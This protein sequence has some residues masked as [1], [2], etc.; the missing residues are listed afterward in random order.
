M[1]AAALARRVFGFLA[2][3]RRD[4]W[5]YLIAPP[6]LTGIFV[7]FVEEIPLSMTLHVLRDISVFVVCLGVP[8]HLVYVNFGERLGLQ[9]RLR[10][11]ELPIHAAILGGAV[12]V[13]TEVAFAILDPLH[14]APLSSSERIPSRPAIWLIGLVGNALVSAVM[15][16]IGGYRERIE[17]MQLRELRARHEALSA[18][19]QA[20]QAR[21]QPHFLFNSLNTVASLI[22][23][24]P[25]RAEAVVEKLAD[26]FRYTLAA[27]QR[28]FVPL[29]DEIDAVASFLELEALRF[30]ERL[31]AALHADPQAAGVPV[32]PLLLQPLVENAVL[33]GIAPR[34]EGGRLEVS[35]ARRAGRL[36]LCVEDDGPGPGGSPRRGSG[37]ALADLRQR[38]ALLYGDAASLDVGRGSLGGF[39]V[40]IALPDG[41]RTEP[42]A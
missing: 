41:A 11:R 16:A 17:E 38:L 3:L 40:E 7:G 14:A 33:H 1:R 9:Y 42:A 37:T 4:F 19:M 36:L 30:G 25:K 35:V 24:D 22:E 15:V 27:S 10:L 20:L 8:V 6:I 39:R 2:P 5:P 32:P 12:L 26:L 29:G 31:K 23:E 21:I 13:G 28:S 18:Q 34:R